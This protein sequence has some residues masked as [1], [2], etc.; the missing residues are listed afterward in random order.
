MEAYLQECI[1]SILSQT[2]KDYE[3]VLIDDGSID[4]SPALCDQLAKKH[5]KIKVV[6][7]QNGGLGSARNA[8]ILSASGD[9]IFFMDADDFLYNSSCLK[10]LSLYLEKRNYPDLL[11]FNMSYY[12]ADSKKFQPWK[13][14]NISI[15]EETNNK[16]IIRKLIQTG[17]F[18]ISACTKLHKRVFLLNNNISFEKGFSEDI[19][20]TIK[21][22]QLAETCS[23]INE[24]IYC[25]RKNV[26]NSITYNFTIRNFEDLFNILQEMCKITDCMECDKSV[27]NAMYSY[28]GYWFWILAGRIWNLDKKDRNNKCIEL[29]KFEWLASYTEH[30]KVKK[31][32]KIYRFCGFYPVSLLCYCHMSITKR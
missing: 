3:I 6:H 11:L 5:S 2:F 8:G 21:V 28:C 22:L 18:P 23:V 27:K 9:Y 24:Y 32:A 16:E 10:Q 30:P 12:Y 31:L 25:Y 4:S 26:K 7:K 20:W 14:Y 17:E 19:L 1:D 13:P 15:T 29:R